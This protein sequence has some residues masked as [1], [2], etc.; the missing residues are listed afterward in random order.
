MPTVYSA[1]KRIGRPK[2]D[3]EAVNVRVERPML[4]AL[5]A[6]IIAQP[7]PKPS[8]P[9]AIRALLREGLAGKGLMQGAG[10]SA[11]LD[12]KTEELQT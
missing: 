11:D 5:D 1:K 7:D 4:G 9:E 8:R 10:N 12:H 2:V 6:Y 3:S